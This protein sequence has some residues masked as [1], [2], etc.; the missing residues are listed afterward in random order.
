MGSTSFPIFMKQY[1][2]IAGM[3]A[4]AIE[5]A[6][7]FAK[8]YGMQTV[9]IPPNV[10]CKRI[11]LPD[12][13]FSDGASKQKALI[14]HIL[15][16][17]ETGQPILVGTHS[18]KE[19]A[20]LAK[21]LRRKGIKIELLNA[22]NDELEADIIADAGAF[23]ALTISTNMA[24]RGT[25]IKLGGKSGKTK[26][27][28]MELGGLHVIGT[29]RHESL[30]IDNQLKGRAGRQGDPGSSQFIVSFE[31]ELMVKYNLKTLL[32]AKYSDLEQS[33]PLDSPVIAKRVMQSQ[34]IIEGQMQDARK[35]LGDYSAVLENQRAIFQHERQE[36]LLRSQ[37]ENND[38]DRIKTQ[39][40][41]NQ[42]DQYWARHLDFA[43]NL[44]EGIYL[45]RLGG[46]NPLR[47]YNRKLKT[48]FEELVME[49]DLFLIEKLKNST[50]EDL[51]K[52]IEK[53][54]STWN[55]VVN[56]S[57]FE[58]QLLINVLAASLLGS[59]RT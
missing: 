50:L 37:E 22:T 19:S 57:P 46:E 12:L 10:P 54:S 11:D 16:V 1:E 29:N 18:V 51:A 13:N 4:T 17:H 27:R 32:P 9:I 55:Y 3:T 6:D 52:E 7:E 14:S 35:N 24:G 49:F 45:L 28:V 2:K 42:Y 59:A 31:D 5:A 8:E 20:D 43:S 44:K 33:E 15:E 40:I 25:D 23:G 58:N 30:R 39:Y 41:L 48:A 21:S 38:E 26:E 53:P 56:D 34:R 36:I 47:Q